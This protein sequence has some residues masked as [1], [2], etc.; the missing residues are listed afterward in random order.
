MTAK[1]FRNS[2]LTGLAVLLLAAAMLFSVLYRYCEEQ[3][4]TDLSTTAAYVAK[5]MELAGEDYLRSLDGP[6]RV[7]WVDADGTVRF[8][9]EADASAMANHA[10]REEIREALET[11]TGRSAHE[12]ETMLVRTLY[13]AQRLPD[14]TVLRLSCTQSAMASMLGAL[15]QALVWITLLMLAADG[16]VSFRLARSI[17]QPINDLDLDAPRAESCYPELRPLINRLNDQNC[18]IR[19]QMEELERRQREFAALSDNMNEGLLVLDRKKNILSFNRSAGRFLASGDRGDR[20]LRRGR[21][22]EALYGAADTALNGAPAEAL[23][24]RDGRTFRVLANPVAER[25]Q[26]TGAVVLLMDVTEQEQRE[27]LR[28]EFSANVSHE[29]KTPLTSISGFAELMKEG[30]VP[31]DKSR[32]FAGDIYRESRRLIGLVD[33]IINLSR[34]DEG[35]GFEW[36]QVDLTALSREVLDQLTPAAEARHVTL[37]LDGE[38][39]NLRGVRQILREMVYNLVDNAIKYNKDGGSVTVS[40]RQDAGQVRLEVADTGIG[41][42]AA[43]QSRVFERFFRVDKSHSKEIGGTGLGLSIVKHGAVLHRAQLALRSE[44]GQGTAITVT[45]PSGTEEVW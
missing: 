31:P 27:A 45:F 12:S 6:D 2:F 34:L 24:A 35:G 18:T 10:G 3:I 28:R 36:E 7:T 16:V 21:C 4:Y 19:R 14:G 13:Y 22:D 9:S 30:L 26:V 44:P 15:V 41:I 39:K 25:G 1:I 29:L 32:E 11:G 23:T 43:Y 17:T 8:D 37:R 40:L 20:L 38:A 33:D 5:G 42:P